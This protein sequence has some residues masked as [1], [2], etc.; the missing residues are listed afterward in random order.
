MCYKCYNDVLEA[1]TFCYS[2]V[3]KGN[4]TNFIQEITTDTLT[5]ITPKR[6]KSSKP[7]RFHLL[8][9]CVKHCTMDSLNLTLTFQKV[10]FYIATYVV[11]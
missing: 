3:T 11:Y 4:S 2:K 8:G 6:I 7:E 5:D 1:A 10:L 9:D